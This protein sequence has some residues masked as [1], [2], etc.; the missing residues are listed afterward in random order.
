MSAL[1]CARRCMPTLE[2]NTRYINLPPPDWLGQH[3]M[4]IVNVF[5]GK[6]NANALACLS[7]RLAEALKTIHQQWCLLMLAINKLIIVSLRNAAPLLVQ[8][9][10]QH[11]RCPILIIPLVPRTVG[12]SGQ[13]RIRRHSLITHPKHTE[14]Y[15]Q[16]L[17]WKQT[18]STIPVEQQSFHVNTSYSRVENMTRIENFPPG[19]QF[20]RW[21]FCRGTTANNQ[22]IIGGLINV[23]RCHL[24]WLVA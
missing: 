9:R 8:Q 2:G 11:V 21:V 19:C 7:F 18:K 5:Y 22:S 14:W 16:L 1:A 10:F 15:R 4:C 24:I 20:E 3:K 12:N 23:F 6:T 13:G 17:G